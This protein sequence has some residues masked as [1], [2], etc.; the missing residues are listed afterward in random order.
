M[1]RLVIS[2]CKEFR[3]DFNT[4][5]IERFSECKLQF[6]NEEV[7]ENLYE[8]Y[9]YVFV[10]EMLGK[11]KNIPILSNRNMPGKMGKWQEYYYFESNYNEQH[12][13]EINIMKKAI[14]ISTENY[15]IFL[16][17][18]DGE[19]WLEIDKGFPES[20]KINPLDYYSAPNNYRVLL[21]T[22]SAEVIKEWK[23]QLEEIERVIL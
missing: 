8:D 16:Y 23:E 12:Y 3:L 2:S 18:C 22:I 19:M 11:L 6:V 7:I 13:K 5:K 21:S 10:D 4:T 17:Q 14:F 15:G 1:I 20:D 9:L